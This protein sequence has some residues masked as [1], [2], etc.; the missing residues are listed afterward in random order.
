M[1]EIA[2]KKI[3]ELLIDQGLITQSQLNEALV[4]Q[5]ASGGKLGEILIK[6]GWLSREELER[7]LATQRGIST[8]NLSGYIIEQEVIKLIPEEFARKY[9]LIPV[10]IIENTLTVA[11]ADPNNVFIIDEIQRIT[12]LNVEPVLAEDLEIRKV[13]DLYYGPTGNLQEIVASIDKEKLADA[14]QLGEEAPII[15][16]VNY[17]IIQAV[18]TKASDIHVEPEEKFLNVRYRVDGM[19]HRQPTLPKDLA[20]A[21]TSRFKIMAGL[22]IAEKRLPQDGRIMMKVGSKDIDFRVSTC[23][24]VH[25]ENVVLRILDRGGLVLGLESLGFPSKPL[26]LFKELIAAPYGIFL[27]TG[28]TGSGKT[29]TLYS[30]LQILNKEDVNIM[31]VEDP[32]EYQFPGIRQ[33]HV[34][35]VAGLTFASALRSFL[36]QDPNII[37]VGEIRDLETAEIAIQAALTGHLVFSTLHTNDSASAFTRLMN[38]GVEPFLVSSSLLGV[39]AQRLLRKICDKCKEFYLPTDNVL[40]NIGLEDKIG[41]NIKLYKGKGCRV[42]NQSGYKGRTGIYELLKVVPE[43]QEAILKKSSA[44]E[45]RAIAVKNGMVTLRQVALE[46]LL[47]GVTT[48]EEVLRVTL[49]TAG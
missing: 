38:M 12:R 16:I 23:P 24:T 22:D 45:I 48:A 17:L 10:F 46:K 31:T 19:L 32:V 15:K 5:K 27:V 9:K 40:K 20:A 6:K 33:V 29:T 8:F 18:Q 1:T 44:D 13:Q 11:M 30:A 25:G 39:L 34:N 35:P 47:A 3:G 28:P 26:V 49:E 37:M 2:Y 42:C 43:I 4:E 7:S 36:R 41:Q 21:I 14:E